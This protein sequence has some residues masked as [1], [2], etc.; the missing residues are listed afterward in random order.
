MRLPLAFLAGAGLFLTAVPAHADQIDG[1]WCSPGGK[2]IHIDG[3]KIKI[4]SGAHITGDYD[5][6]GFRYVGPD[7][8]PEAGHEVRMAQQHDG[9][10]L[11]WRRI[12]GTEGAVEEWRR[13]QVTS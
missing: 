12:D 11:V 4:P 7:G 2:H 8:D 1:D 10:I 6:H 5:R 9:L 3:P 13:C